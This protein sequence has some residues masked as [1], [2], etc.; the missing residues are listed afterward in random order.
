MRGLI[1]VVA[2][3]VQACRTFDAGEYAPD[4]G[5]PPGG[6]IEGDS[7]GADPLPLADIDCETAPLVNWSNFGHAF[8]IQNCNGCHS[9]TTH[10][11][12]GAPEHA[13]FDSADDVWAQKSAVLVAAGGE[14]PRM[15]PNGGTTDMERAKLAIWLQCGEAGE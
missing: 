2:V 6:D 12:Y 15:P 7:G 10:N 4:P 13:I 1:V 5:T 9:A 11:R 8:M 14:G 3:S